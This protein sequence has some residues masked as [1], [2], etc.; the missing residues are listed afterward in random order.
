MVRQSQAGSQAAVVRA[1]LDDRVLACVAGRD[2]PAMVGAVSS[3]DYGG[4]VVCAD[5][6][7]PV[8]KICAGI[9]ALDK[10]VPVVADLQ[11]YR[12]GYATEARA[13][14]TGADGG[15]FEL[16]LRE[17]IA[18]HLDSQRAAGA[19]VAL[20]PSL[21]VRDRDDRALERLV[22]EANAFDHDDAVLP[23]PLDC[24]WLSTRSVENVAKAL[25]RSRL[26]S[27]L[28]AGHVDE[29]GEVELVG[30]G[31]G[32]G[33]AVSVFAEDQVGL[34]AARVVSLERIRSM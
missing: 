21:F 29:A 15:L 3:Y 1:A 6:L 13:M 32:G 4:F 7:D 31:D 34:A 8:S 2:A 27:R 16:P 24:E 28:P 19:A 20:F 5:K 18:A 12:K 26:Y 14:Y 30:D 25:R 22:V 17:V 33:G 9:E 10:N 23:V 11:T